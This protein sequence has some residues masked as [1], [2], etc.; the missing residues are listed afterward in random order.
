MII[1][2]LIF[3]FSVGSYYDHYEIVA[4]L[5]YA[6]AKT[7]IL[8]NAKLLA[9]QECVKS[10]DSIVKTELVFNYFETGKTVIIFLPS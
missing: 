2:I 7:D 3:D 1:I 8:N 6:G 10:I 5:L 4:L 9:K